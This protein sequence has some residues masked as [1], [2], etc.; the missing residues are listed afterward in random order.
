[1]LKK[2]GIINEE[3]YA[4]YKVTED[5]EGVIIGT[6]KLKNSEDSGEPIYVRSK[7]KADDGI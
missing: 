4:D 5:G 3:E 2:E 1:M 7:P 6:V